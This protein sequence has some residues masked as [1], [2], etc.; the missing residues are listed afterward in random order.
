M[1]QTIQNFIMNAKIVLR[2]SWHNLAIGGDLGGFFRSKA[3]SPGFSI[4]RKKGPH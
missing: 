1:Q 3:A 2:A 4:G